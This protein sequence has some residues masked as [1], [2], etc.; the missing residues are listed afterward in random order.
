MLNCISTE[1]NDQSTPIFPIRLS[2]F[3]D[4]LSEQN[5][6]LNNA[7]LSQN[8]GQ[9]PGQFFLDYHENGHLARVYLIVTDDLNPYPIGA[10]LNHLPTRDY[11]ID[12][13]DLLTTD[14]LILAWG[15]GCYRYERYLSK[16]KT[17]NLIVADSQRHYSALSKVV[18]THL[19]RDLINTPADDMGPVELAKWVDDFAKEHKATTRHVVGEDLL[20]ERFPSI[21]IVGRASHKAPRLIEMSWGDDHHPRI[22]LVGKGVCFDTGGNNMKADTYMKLM[23]KD[24]GGAAHVLGL[25]KLIIDHQLP[26]RLQVLIPAVENAVSANAY[27]QGDIVTTRSGQTVE[28]GH[29]D[30]EG[31]V[32]LADTL[33]YASEF[34][35]ELIIDY[36]TLTG[37]ARIALGPTLTPTFSNREDFNQAIHHSGTATHDLTWPMPLYHGYNKYIKPKIADLSNSASLPQAGCITAALFLEHFVDVDIPWVHIDTYGW[38]FGDRTGGIEGGEALAMI[39]IFNW[40]Q[41]DFLH[42]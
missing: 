22:A 11:H 36:A 31:R 34:K 7:M 14:A 16:Q 1:A 13:D 26:V 6:F 39:A 40:L 35:P 42:D 41:K 25:A 21:H 38:N 30:A 33:T 18:A 24:M 10:N 19:V 29:T 4:W 32:I 8:F 20:N 5:N 23:K 37:A 9:K 17:P 28:I 12:C 15:Y 27:R 3:A 2:H